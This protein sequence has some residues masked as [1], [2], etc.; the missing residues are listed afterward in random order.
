[1]CLVVS[2]D[3]EGWSFLTGSGTVESMLQRARIR[4]RLVLLPL[5]PA[6]VLG[7]VVGFD[8][9]R[10]PATIAAA[11][12]TAVLGIAGALFV[13]ASITRPLKD[14]ATIVLDLH[15]LRMLD[16]TGRPRD[17]MLPPRKLRAGGELADLA[18]AVA[19]GRRHAADLVT[20]QLAARRSVTDLVANIALRNERLLGAA[21]DALGEIGRRDHEPSTAAAIA[22]V[23][24]IVARVDRATASAL[25]LIGEGGRVATT[26]SSIT[27]VVWAAALAIE[28]SDRVD[29]LALSSAT[30]HADAVADIAH[31][32]AELID[33]AV[34]ASA[35][36]GRVTILGAG[37]AD[38]G[39]ELTIMD[40]GSGLGAR[41][42]DTANRRVRRLESLHRVPVRHIGLD[43]VGR[44]ARRHGI[45]ARLGHA[46]D[47]GV[48]VRVLLPAAILT[49]P[50]HPESELLPESP[51]VQLALHGS[52]LEH[53][54]TA[55]PSGDAVVDIRT[56]LELVVS[57]AGPREHDLSHYEPA[58]TPG[59][60]TVD[61]QTSQRAASAVMPKRAPIRLGASDE[62]LPKRDQRK[63]AA[64]IARARN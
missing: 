59:A 34:Q 38:G 44:L 8:L 63:W 61:L 35:A 31:M 39:Y 37:A 11:I 27:D 4:T 33:N 3:H 36:P 18:I 1:M 51:V 12:V 6:A 64:A 20:E 62:F 42:L 14:L 5:L 9:H 7:A 46:A 19:D 23:H 15:D 52:G 41:E 55:G 58:P 32:I 47:G 2:R 45:H 56:P 48:V 53:M 50:A 10:S 22:R 60:W 57:A 25:V 16:G 17:D 40:S 26:A 54:T 21:L 28:S 29:A 24:R 43:V 13:S 30:I 49:V